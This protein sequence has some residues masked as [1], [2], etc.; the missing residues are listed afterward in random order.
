MLDG[1]TTSGLQ[2]E[3]V[4][5]CQDPK[6]ISAIEGRE[7]LGV[8]ALHGSSRSPLEVDVLIARVSLDQSVRLQK[9][10]ERLSRWLIGLTCGLFALTLALVFLGVV[11]LVKH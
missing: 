3:A 8:F 7:L 9:S 2:V 10:N 4:R 1:S 11:P 6:P 5:R